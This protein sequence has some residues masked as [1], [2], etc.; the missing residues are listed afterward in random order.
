MGN[1][2]VQGI[3]SLTIS[4]IVQGGR[5]QIPEAGAVTWW[6]AIGMRRQQGDES[7]GRVVGNRYAH[8]R[9]IRSC[10]RVVDSRYQGERD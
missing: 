4:N 10:G 6:W 8:G 7:C 9:G 5:R 1:R 3:G 2:Y